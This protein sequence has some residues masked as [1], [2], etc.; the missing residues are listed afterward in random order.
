MPINLNKFCSTFAFM[1]I[2]SI[3]LGALKLDQFDLLALSRLFAQK[4]SSREFVLS[5]EVENDGVQ[6]V[7][8]LSCL[9][10]DLPKFQN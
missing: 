5:N 6:K 8:C 1:P 7:C 3:G 9:Q 2:K 4:S 10:R